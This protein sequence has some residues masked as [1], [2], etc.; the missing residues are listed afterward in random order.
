ML[1]IWPWLKGHGQM[2]NSDFD[3]EKDLS[4][5]VVWL[6]GCVAVIQLLDLRLQAS[7][8]LDFLSVGVLRY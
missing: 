7:K 4:K 8:L 1:D 6:E 2:Y 3:E 5:Q